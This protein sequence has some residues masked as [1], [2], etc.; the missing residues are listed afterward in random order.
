M[1]IKLVFAIA[2]FVAY[3]CSETDREDREDAH[4]EMHQVEEEEEQMRGHHDTMDGETHGM[5]ESYPEDST[6]MNDG[7]M[8]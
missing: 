6:E 4:E 2:M 1:F 7:H 3:A 5:E 8:Q